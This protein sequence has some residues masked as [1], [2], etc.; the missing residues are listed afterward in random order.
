M[1]QDKLFGL[2]SALNGLDFPTSPDQIDLFLEVYQDYELRS[3]P[4]RINPVKILADSRRKEPEPPTA[5]DYHKRTVLAAEI[6]FQLH[7]EWSMGRLKLQKLM[8]LAQETTGMALHT[9]FLKQANGPY[10]PKLMRS[11]ESQFLK[12]HWFVYKAVEKEKYQLLDKAGGHRE[13][14][15]RYYSNEMQDISKIIELFRRLNTNQVE[16]IATLYSCWKEVNEEYQK[17]D[18]DVVVTK[19]YKWSDEKKKFSLDQIKNAISWME[20]NLIFPTINH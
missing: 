8:Y 20:D 1:K 7:N 11:L 2:I 19:F 3:D 13:W 16:L 17:F 5:V 14:Y 15:E 9:N 10:D 6:V 12:N 18:L 4:D